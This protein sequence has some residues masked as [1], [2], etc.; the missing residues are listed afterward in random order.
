MAVS[1]IKKFLD[2]GLQFT[3]MSRQQAESLV[4]SLVKAGEVRRKE[5]DELVQTLIE[6][7]RETSEHISALVQQE[8]SK[9]MAALASQFEEI[10]ARVET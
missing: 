6:R 8:V 1:P 9:Q 10:E 3:E 4:K 5:A 2:A 7:S